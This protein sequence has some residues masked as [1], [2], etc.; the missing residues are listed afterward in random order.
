VRAAGILF[1]VTTVGILLWIL[2]G[3]ESAVEADPSAEP[4]DDGGEAFD[5][6]ESEGE[7]AP[8]REGDWPYCVL[9]ED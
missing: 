2:F 9:C 4:E 8:S 7:E 1:L 5:P 3:D 6:R